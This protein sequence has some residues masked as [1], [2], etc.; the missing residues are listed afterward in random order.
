MK[1]KIGKIEKR[2]GENKQGEYTQW[3][4]TGTNEKGKDVVASFFNKPELAEQLKIGKEYDLRIVKKGNFYNIEGIKEEK[5]ET[6]NRDEKIEKMHQEKTENIIKSVALNNATEL[7]KHLLMS[8]IEL[9]M[10]NIEQVAMKVIEI[11]EIF[12]KY[13]KE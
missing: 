4:I 9:E 10:S 3:I 5:Q 7:M 11:A 12:K 6:N 8:N 2:S 13:L 1:M